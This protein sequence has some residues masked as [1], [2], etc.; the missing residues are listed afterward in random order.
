ML[1]TKVP[2]NVIKNV[3]LIINL[4]KYI[5]KSMASKNVRI[6]TDLIRLSGGF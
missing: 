4:N 1:L 5:V 6:S 3:F 2:L